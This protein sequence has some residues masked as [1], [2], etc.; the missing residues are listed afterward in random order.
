MGAQLLAHVLE[1]AVKPA[2]NKEVGWFPVFPTDEAKELPWF[3]EL[4]KS[5][6][7]V[8]HWHA[9]KFELPYRA[10]NLAS[11]SANKNQAFAI[12]DQLLGLQ[13]HVE[14]TPASVSALI[15]NA[16]ADIL[17]GNFIQDEA[18]LL[19]GIQ[20]IGDSDTCDRLLTHF[21]Q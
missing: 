6:P 15:E 14:T 7:V 19:A 18:A 5:H 20:H 13:F 8:F 12:G 9:D 21:F 10:L 4:F 11:S 16:K 3:Y 17:P 1:A 2:A